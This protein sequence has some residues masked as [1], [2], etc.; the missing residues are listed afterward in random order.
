M[1]GSQ[2]GGRKERGEDGYYR[3]ASRVAPR[4]LDLQ[5]GEK[6]PPRGSASAIRFR[7]MI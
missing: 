6:F 7:E 2:G 4:A 5:D 3:I 1:T